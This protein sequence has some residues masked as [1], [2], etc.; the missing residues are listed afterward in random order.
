[1]KKIL[2]IGFA[3]WTIAGFTS[4]NRGS[5]SGYGNGELVGSRRSQKWL[6]PRPYGMVFIRRGSFTIGPN[7]QDPAWS[8]IPAKT[9]SIDAFWMDD[10]EITNNEY[11]QFTN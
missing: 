9:V 1:M 11:R 4:C 8:S 7:D 2:L 6:E 3:L 5:S 10:T